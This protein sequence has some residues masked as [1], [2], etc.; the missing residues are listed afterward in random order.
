MAKRYRNKIFGVT[1][2]TD[3]VLGVEWEEI[4]GKEPLTTVSDSGKVLSSQGKEISPE[5][6]DLIGSDETEKEED[7]DGSG[8]TDGRGDKSGKASDSKRSGARRSSTSKS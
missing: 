7:T 3:T 8:E 1:V 5:D 2:T 4:T 6:E